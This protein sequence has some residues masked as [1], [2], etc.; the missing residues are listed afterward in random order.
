MRECFICGR[1]NKIEK[2]H[3]FNGAYRRKSERFGLTVDLCHDCHNEPP[4]GAHHN[5]ET[6]IMIKQQGQMKAMFEQG[7][8]T[9]QFIEEFGKNYL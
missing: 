4:N 3:I 8:T 2:H 6:M 7:W 1:T 5:A 9:E